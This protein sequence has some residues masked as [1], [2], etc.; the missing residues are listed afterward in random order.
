MPAERHVRHVPEDRERDQTIAVAAC[1]GKVLSPQFL[2]WIAPLV[3]LSRSRIAT[4]LLGAAILL[5]NVLF[6]DRYAGLVARHGGEVWLLV[7]RNAL[8]V[9]LLVMLLVAQARR[10]DTL[11]A[12]YG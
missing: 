12:A 7:T 8:L 10:T 6:P 3:V 5:T 4:V 1:A 11:A 2:L 9:G